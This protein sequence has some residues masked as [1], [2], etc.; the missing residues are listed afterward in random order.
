[1]DVSEPQPLPYT[2]AAPGLARRYLASRAAAW[3][4]GLLDLVELL[5]SEVVSNAVLHGHGPVE[6]LLNDD[7]TRLRVEVGD[8]APG[9]LPWMPG[10]PADGHEQGRGLLIVDY[11]ADR[12]GCRPHATAP[13]KIVWFELRYPTS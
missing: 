12:W 9:P 2:S 3:P 6:L 10:Q 11:L 8:G 1:V 5:A 7:G 13:G 4:A